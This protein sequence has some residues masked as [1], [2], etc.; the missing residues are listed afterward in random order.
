MAVDLSMLQTPMPSFYIQHPNETHAQPHNPNIYAPVPQQ[1]HGLNG[2][3]PNL[4][5]DTQA[6]FGLD[7]RQYPMSAATTAPSEYSQSPNF[8][9]HG[10]ESTPLPVNTPYS[11]TF[12]SPMPQ[13][14]SMPPPSASPLSY[15]SHHGEPAIME[16][17]PPP[18]GMMPRSASADIYPMGESAISDDGSSLN[19][20]YSKHT[21]NLPLH[22]HSPA[23]NDN[24]QSELDMNSLVQFDPV[25]TA[26]MSPENLAH[27]Q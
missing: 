18:L 12:L 24:G 7:M 1:P 6:G 25:D 26:S 9:A 3:T 8:F 27:T 16:Q 17:S 15:G 14:A 21:I 19:E 20:M 13:S 4:R 23:Y 11:S 10:H 22:P 2:V 5:I